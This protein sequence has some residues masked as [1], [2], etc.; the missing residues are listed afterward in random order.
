M[1]DGISR[2]LPLARSYRRIAQGCERDASWEVDGRRAACKAMRAS[3]ANGVRDGFLR[4]LDDACRSPWLFGDEAARLRDAV[5]PCLPLQPLEQ[6][7]MQH[8]EAA[9]D[10]GEQPNVADGLL[11]AMQDQLDGMRRGIEHKLAGEPRD[12]GQLLRRWD[13]SVE[14]ASIEEMV[15][16]RCRA[17]LEGGG[18]MA[19]PPAAPPF[20]P[21][22]DLLTGEALE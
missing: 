4:R 3:L 21:D 22:A 1:R 19:P 5:T 17:A 20:D 6:E 10:F 2:G 8:V 14:G 9:I 7:T 16:D 11:R 13:L 15:S 12:R 18:P